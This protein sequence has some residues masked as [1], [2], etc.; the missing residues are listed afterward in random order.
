M[1]LNRWLVQEHEG[2]LLAFVSSTLS[3]PAGSINTFRRELD[4]PAGRELRTAVRSQVDDAGSYSFLLWFVC[5]DVMWSPLTLW[6]CILA[7]PFMSLIS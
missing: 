3:P 5:A 1:Q 4:S 2:R 7:R 6:G